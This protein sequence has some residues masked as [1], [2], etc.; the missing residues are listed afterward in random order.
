MSAHRD[1][2]RAAYYQRRREQLLT[3][4]VNTGMTEEL[5]ERWI[6]AWEDNQPTREDIGST[7]DYWKAAGRWIGKMRQRRREP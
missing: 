5:A 1:G 4:L 3:N 6:K 2:G 7:V